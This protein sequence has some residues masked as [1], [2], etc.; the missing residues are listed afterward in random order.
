MATLTTGDIAFISF[1]ADEDGWAIATFVDIDPNTSIYF[2]DNE[3]TSTTAFNTGESYFQWVSGTSTISAGTVIRF[4]AVDSS[5]LLASSV[6]TLSRA[7]VSGS[8][9]Y[10]LS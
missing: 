9:N 3:A 6:G 2:T 1:N 7:T 4:S 5:T 10:G 8:T